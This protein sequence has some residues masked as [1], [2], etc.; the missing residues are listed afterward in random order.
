MR[1]S[2]YPVPRNTRLTAEVDAAVQLLAAADG[3]TI[4][5]WIREQVAKEARR[6]L[7]TTVSVGEGESRGANDGLSVGA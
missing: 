6:R 3:L 7:E 2:R 4:G 5:E 1:P